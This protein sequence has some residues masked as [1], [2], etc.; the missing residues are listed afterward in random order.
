MVQDLPLYLRHYLRNV[1]FN[2]NINNKDNFEMLLFVLPDQELLKCNL[3]NRNIF[4]TSTHIF[5]NC[6]AYNFDGQ[7][8]INVPY[9]TK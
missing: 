4:E 9:I 7:N 2:S 8:F 3:C 1:S 5:N 6:F